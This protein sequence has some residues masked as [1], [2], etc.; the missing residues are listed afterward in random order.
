[1]GSN[2]KTPYQFL[3]LKGEAVCMAE[4]YA[5]AGGDTGQ[6]VFRAHF[7]KNLLYCST[8]FSVFIVQIQNVL[9]KSLR[10]AVLSPESRVPRCLP[11][12]QKCAP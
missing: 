8:A 9:L 1:M 4:I 10:I 7:L 2:C 11:N 6:T 3:A 12:D 5:D